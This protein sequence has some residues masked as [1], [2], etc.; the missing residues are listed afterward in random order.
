MDD[1]LQIAICSGL[2][3]SYN[4]STEKKAISQCPTNAFGVF[5]TVK[6]SYT[7]QEW[8]HDIHGCI[9]Y[10][11]DDYKKFLESIIDDSSNKK[12]KKKQILK[13][14]TDMSTD[15]EVD[16]T[17]KLVPGVMGKLMPKKADYGC[18]QL[19]KALGL[20]TTRTTTNMNL[21]DSH[22]Q[23]KKF[24]TIYEIMESYFDVRHELYVKRKEYQMNKMAEQLVKLSN[25]A[26][27]IQEQIVEPPTLILR[28]KKK[29]QVIEMLKEKGYDIIGDDNEYKYLRNMTIDSVEEENYE[30]LL[31]LKGE[32]EKELEKIKSTTIEDM[33]LAELSALEKEYIRYKNDRVVRAKGI[34]AKIK[35]KKIKKKKKN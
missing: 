22:Q 10:W 17:L 31:K 29:A 18:N 19:E 23:L 5:S 7:L 14:Y 30:K 26:R 4:L 6:R 8:P 28:K 27:F 32:R 21:F 35:K 15:T 20:Y 2:K 12:N 11:T 9:G 16:I 34:G 25:K 33:W 3:F 1:I 24:T 13:N